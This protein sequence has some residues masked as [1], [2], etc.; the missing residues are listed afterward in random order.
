[1]SR[2]R[3]PDVKLLANREPGRAVP[4]RAEPIQ[5]A[6]PSAT[7]TDNISCRLKAVWLRPIKQK[8]PAPC[9]RSLTRFTTPQKLLHSGCAPFSG[10]VPCVMSQRADSKDLLCCGKQLSAKRSSK[11]TESRDAVANISFISKAALQR[12][13]IISTVWTHPERLPCG[14]RPWFA[15][16]QRGCLSPSSCVGPRPEN[17]NVFTSLGGQTCG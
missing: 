3:N 16:R 11:G 14:V 15:L 7:A 10:G 8:V 17:N 4:S 12:N 2:R 5:S 6:P 1:M 9:W 13:H